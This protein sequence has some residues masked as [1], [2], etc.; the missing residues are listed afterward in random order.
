MPSKSRYYIKVSEFRRLDDGR[1]KV[2]IGNTYAEVSERVFEHMSNFARE[3]NTRYAMGTISKEEMM[4]TKSRFTGEY[5]V[6][7]G[8]TSLFFENI[9]KTTGISSNLLFGKDGGKGIQ[10]RLS[11][12][13]IDEFNKLIDNLSELSK[14]RAKA[15]ELY[16][17][18]SEIFKDVSNF[19]KEYLSHG[20]KLSDLTD[21]DIRQ[22][23]SN[24][25]L[26]NER[27]DSILHPESTVTD[28]R[29]RRAITR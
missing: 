5:A 15:Q 4:R 6:D 29:G 22:F 2:R 8:K 10:S 18:L 26:I 28:L 13:Q 11:K 9:L 17:Q 16:E 1:V 27:A 20:Q 7:V 24:V 25:K 23:M 21:E 19:Y 3:W 12:E 14:D